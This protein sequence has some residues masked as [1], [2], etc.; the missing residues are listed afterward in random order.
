MKTLFVLLPLF[1]AVFFSVAGFLLHFNDLGEIS[2]LSSTAEVVE[3]GLIWGI[4]IG[5]FFVP[6]LS[7]FS[8]AE[9]RSQ[10]PI[11]MYALL[12]VMALICFFCNPWFFYLSQVA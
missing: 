2:F 6:A 1:V 11:K 4:F 10:R 9:L 7:K 12:L 5:C 3:V 8:K